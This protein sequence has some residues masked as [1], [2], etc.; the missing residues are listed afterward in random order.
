[1]SMRPIVEFLCGEKSLRG[2]WFGQSLPQ[3]P[4]HVYWWRKPLRDAMFAAEENQRKLEQ[5]LANQAATIEALQAQLDV[6]LDHIALAQ[7]AMDLVHRAQSAG[8]SLTIAPSPRG[9]SIVQISSS[10]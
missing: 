6:K 8:L 3:R 10:S 4:A 7:A 1:M 5:Q 9:S 2:V